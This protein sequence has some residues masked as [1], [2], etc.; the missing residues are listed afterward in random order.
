MSRRTSRRARLYITRV[1]PW[2]VTKA[3]F[4]LSLALGVVLVLVVVGTYWLVAS[5]GVVDTTSTAIDDVLGTGEFDV[6]PAIE[7]SRV[8]GFASLVALAQVISITA[9]ATLVSFVYNIAA[10]LTGGLEVV[11][12]ED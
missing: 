3:A 8:V 4:V 12:A 7:F 10:T 6:L 1:D 2:S 11:L 5:T 9:L